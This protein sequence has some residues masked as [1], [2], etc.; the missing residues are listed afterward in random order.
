MKK[1][2]LHLI[3][4]VFFLQHIDAQQFAF[5][6]DL[7]KYPVE[8]EKFFDR[9][10]IKD[11]ENLTDALYSLWNS[12]K[13]SQS[14]KA[15]IIGFSNLMLKRRARA[16]PH[17][18]NLLNA[19]IAFGNSTQGVDSFDAWLT[20]LEKMLP[21]KKHF[22]LST[23]NKFHEFTYNLLKFNAL[24]KSRGTYWHSNS[25]NFHFEYVNNQIK[26]IFD[27]INLTCNIRR[28]SITIFDTKGILYPLDYKWVGEGGRLTWERF[29]RP[30]KS[31]KRKKHKIDFDPH[32]VYADLQ[33][34]QIDVKSVKLQADSVNFVFEKYFKRPILGKLYDKITAG[35]KFET[36]TYPR[37]SS[38]TKRFAI[39]S[40]AED[41]SYNGG[42]SMQGKKIIG[43]G[44]EKQD[45]YLTMYRDKKPFVKI[46]TK[47]IVFQPQVI[48]S[49]KSAVTIYIGNDS[50]YHHSLLFKYMKGRQQMSLI[51]DGKGMSKSLYFNT[52]HK[53]KM[54][55]E[56]LTW[57]KGDSAIYMGNLPG[58]GGVISRAIF[59]SLNYFE[60]SDFRKLQQ[61]DTIN[62]VLALKLFLDKRAKWGGYGHFDDF[63]MQEYARER[64]QS[65]HSIERTLRALSYKG[66]LFYDEEKKYAHAT[67]Y[68]FSYLKSRSGKIDHDI[69]KLYSGVY[70]SSRFQ[71]DDKNTSLSKNQHNGIL[72]LTSYNLRLFGV[73]S[74]PIIAKKKTEFITL[75]ETD[76]IAKERVIPLTIKSR[77]KSVT[78][79]KN[80]D[81]LFDGE[82]T[83]GA[84]TFVGSKFFFNYD[85]FIFNLDSVDYL[86]I[87]VAEYDEYG[88]I[89]DRKPVLNQIEGIT[90]DLYVDDPNNK[91][92]KDTLHQYPIFISEKDSYVYY[93]DSTF[94]EVT[95]PR[96]NFFFKMFPYTVDSLNDFSTNTWKLPGEFTSG[97][98]MPVI[99]DS[100]AIQTDTTNYFSKNKNKYIS[101]YSLGFDRKIKST[102]TPLYGG[103]GKFYDSMKLSMKGLIGMGR[104]DYISSTTLAKDFVFYIDSLTAS[105]NLFEI[106][107]RAKGVEFPEADVTKA[108]IVWQPYKD[109][110]KS[111]N[112][113]KPFAMFGNKVLAGDSIKLWGSLIVT[114][115]GLEGSGTMR[116]ANGTLTSNRYKYKAFSLEGD[117][118]NFSL[119]ADVA[120]IDTSF[121]LRNTHAMVSFV[122]K[123][124]VFQANKGGSYAEFPI[125]KYVC[126]MDQF[127]WNMNQDKIAMT[128][129]D[130]T[131]KEDLDEQLFMIGSEFISIHP[132]QDSLHFIA[133]S[134]VY[135]LRKHVIIA[136]DVKLIKTGDASIYPNE[137]V[138]IHPNAQM[139]VLHTARMI[140]NRS[141][142]YHE[143]H[144]ANVNIKGR[145]KYTASGDYHY[146]DETGG[147]QIIHFNELKLDTAMNTV[148]SGKILVNQSFTLSPNYEFQGDVKLFA[149]KEF[150]E[151]AGYV[152][153]KHDCPQQGRHKIKFI[154]EIDPKEIYIPLS[155]K[156]RDVDKRKI[157]AAI[158]LTN[159]NSHI[160]SS[161]LTSRKGYS[162][163]PVL[164]ALP[165]H[166]VPIRKAIT[167]NP[168]LLIRRQ[169][170]DTLK[171]TRDSTQVALRDT[172]NVP[173]VDS[174]IL[175]EKEQVLNQQKDTIAFLFYDKKL[176]KYKISNKEKL[177]DLN[178]LG[179]YLELHTKKCKVYG[180]GEI[181]LVPDL[182][183]VELV[184]VGNVKHNLEN[185]ETVL[186]LNLGINFY[187]A[188]SAMDLMAE[189]II[190]DITL[191][192]VDLSRSVYKKALRE[193]AGERTAKYMLQ[194]M[195]LEGTFDVPQIMQFTL[196]L[197][198]LKLK[199]NTQTHSYRSVGE[200][201]I[202]SI[203]DFPVNRLVGGHVELVH[204]RR[205]D[206]LN[207]YFQVGHSW[208]FF[209]YANGVMNSIS[210]MDEFN[211]IISTMKEKERKQ[212]G[213]R[214]VPDYIFQISDVQVK[215]KFARQFRKEE[216]QKELE[217]Q[218][219]N[220]TDEDTNQGEEEDDN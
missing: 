127:T 181:N 33:N 180:E 146:I 217:E 71:M 51:R 48:I 177:G 46:A 218:E 81:F 53:L 131:P 176:E 55:I 196:Y 121:I 195:K 130:Q 52:Y 198:Q 186:E 45:A 207:M 171:V 202:G 132:K 145:L 7:V 94:Q 110:L 42:F 205:G 178:E 126:Y 169:Q 139:Q 44:D 166:N 125:N 39:D 108:D 102:G 197:N 8:M 185:K 187:F 56:E 210:S 99:R 47:K 138:I 105:A 141:L 37:F 147:K 140:V 192:G 11:S 90:G 209:T 100:M 57:T 162:D 190:Q 18:T 194:Q 112:T 82:L 111:T 191:Q 144:N 79:K 59:E 135:N 120:D 38:Y 63:T 96:K 15:R 13:I 152:R 116:F 215:N 64:R 128:T 36:A 167:V 137:P 183:Q 219:N 17:F 148:G 91:A 4:S 3:F 19:F 122:K 85:K 204:R 107:K 29:A 43:T 117:S 201:G 211:R 115:K 158:F 136:N 97:G 73:D 161:F 41:F 87:T 174:L 14:Q 168:D 22:T 35:A 30:R 62:P 212:S 61:I 93:S 175:A 24:N 142:R 34:Y 49:P 70:R 188:L 78:F 72:D 157:F 150:L 123:S 163:N 25:A 60:K 86:K 69:I 159:E 119:K 206:V 16:H 74:I 31:K 32:R 179:N 200:I 98:I 113:V 155:A 214:G 10:K 133:K 129:T 165:R 27:K 23:I 134:S 213:A 5:S 2:Y 6:G 54:D 40:I 199:W 220:A 104:L 156:P 143:L 173:P 88:E 89:V 106:D 80:R 58:S 203:N 114:P 92:G 95:Y 65:R 68:L 164:S 154:S 149:E 151:F 9:V 124:G 193:I 1:I 160:Y 67:D 184:S 182:G 77:D 170:A 109:R 66:F 118:T 83:V 208:F 172:I 216:L 21:D 20:I 50:I 189:R 101:V 84:F 153:L 103:K 26:V 28:D 76:S 75:T 12:D